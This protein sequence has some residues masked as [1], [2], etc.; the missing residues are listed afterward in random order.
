MRVKSKTYPAKKNRSTQCKILDPPLDPPSQA[1]LTRCYY[2][3]LYLFA[4]F[5]LHPDALDDFS[6]SNDILSFMVTHE[7][8]RKRR[9]SQ[10]VRF[11]QS[12][13]TYCSAQNGYLFHPFCVRL[14]FPK[15]KILLC[16]IKL[17]KL[18]MSAI[19]NK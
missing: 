11:V 10:A 1:I 16:L 18:S 7:V 6:F 14:L 3:T 19:V 12:Q 13:K 5:L 15:F 9:A 4:T 17:W 8:R 2:N